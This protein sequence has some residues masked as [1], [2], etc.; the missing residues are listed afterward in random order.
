[1]AELHAGSRDRHNREG[2][3]CP[4]PN[5]S[6]RREGCLLQ[7]F[8]G[9]FQLSSWNTHKSRP[10]KDR[11]SY[12]RV[13]AKA[14]VC[15]LWLYVRIPWGAF[16]GHPCPG[17]ILRQQIHVS[18]GRAWAPVVLKSSPGDSNSGPGLRTTGLLCTAFIKPLCI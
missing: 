4:R 9:S 13:T 1:M 5:H 3:V 8:G 7:L 15:S 17:S 16:K 14:L 18:G 6:L 11:S 12:L 2:A 10:D